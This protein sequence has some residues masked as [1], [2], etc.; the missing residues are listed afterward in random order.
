[1]RPRMPQR[2]A[3]FDL[4]RTLIRRESA[5][6]YVAYQRAI[7]EASVVDS[8]RMAWWVLQYTLG[9]IDVE[10]VA[11]KAFATV[12]GKSE[13]SLAARCDDWVRNYVAPHLSDGARRTVKEHADAGHRLAIVTGATTYTAWP[14]ARQLGIPHVLATQL[15]IDDAGNFTGEAVDPLCYGAG[16][17]T[18]VQELATQEGFTFD[19][20]VFYTDSFT[21]LPLLERVG[22]PVVVNPDMRLKRE[23][24]RRGWRVEQW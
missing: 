9:V 23:A 3:L 18:R 21:D 1:M 19:D 15:A 7:G 4:D 24:K 10:A 6:L 2:V 5:S 12:R 16:K 13:V 22:E 20:C 8:A 17:I 11:K 14:I